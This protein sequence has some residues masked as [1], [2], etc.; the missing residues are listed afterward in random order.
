[1]VGGTPPYTGIPSP[2]TGGV[3]TPLTAS[4]GTYQYTFIGTVVGSV[5]LTFTD[6]ANPVASGVFPITVTSH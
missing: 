4:S 3:L 6:S 2:S 5:S 1:V